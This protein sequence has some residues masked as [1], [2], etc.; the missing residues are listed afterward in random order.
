MKSFDKKFG[1]LH[2][3]G[4]GGIGMSGIAEVLVN[5]GYK[6]SGSDLVENQNVKRLKNLGVNIFKGHHKSNIDDADMVVV[7]SA[8]DSKNEEVLEAKTR[9]LPIVKRA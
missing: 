5:L 4:I 6:V 7:S 8:I 9:R 2:F 1:L 3:I